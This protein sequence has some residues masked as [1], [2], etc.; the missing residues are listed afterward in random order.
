M[1]SARALLQPIPRP[2]RAVVALVLAWLALASPL[3][4]PR[5][6]VAR[7]PLWVVRDPDTTLYLFGSVHVLPPY[8]GWLSGPVKRAVVASDMVMLELAPGA[9]ERERAVLQALGA[10]SPGA[11]LRDRLP[12]DCAGALD[13]AGEAIGYPPGTFDR[14]A[15]WIVQNEIG[16]RAIT[17]AGYSVDNGVEAALTELARHRG[18]PVLGLEKAAD[19]WR[20]FAGVTE[21]DQRAALC[22]LLAD[23][24][25]PVAANAR[26]VAAWRRGDVAALTAQFAA[27][28][29]SAPPGLWDAL[30][31]ARNE[32]WT[33]WI[34]HRMARPGT[35]FIAV[36]TGHLVGSGS[37]IERLRARGMTVSRLQ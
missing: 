13:K 29:A 12:R 21:R 22:R 30:V 9:V 11:P 28:R 33:G 37:V 32:R 35:V 26:A 1:A 24:Q 2:A 36:G 18:K 16:G 19:Q 4:A 8:V 7:P 17:A 3:P 15:P 20:A 5:I 14:A 23:P 6:E 10:L 27:D 31:T 25:A 34:V